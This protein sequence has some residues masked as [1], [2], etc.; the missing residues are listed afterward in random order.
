MIHIPIRD[1]PCNFVR[2]ISAR[3][4]KQRANA[5]IIKIGANLNRVH[6]QLAII[7]IGLT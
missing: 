4:A 6:L 7:A 2:I 3:K 5:S 1:A